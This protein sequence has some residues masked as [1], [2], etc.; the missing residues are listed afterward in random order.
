VGFSEQPQRGII[1]PVS[2]VRRIRVDVE[3]LGF[4]AH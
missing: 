3:D 1:N 4:G 2:Q